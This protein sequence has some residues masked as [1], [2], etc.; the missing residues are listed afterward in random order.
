MRRHGCA[1]E[2]KKGGDD[3][4]GKRMFGAG[5]HSGRWKKG[6]DGKEGAE[7]RGDVRAR[8]CLWSALNPRIDGGVAEGRW[9]RAALRRHPGC[10]TVQGVTAMWR[11]FDGGHHG[12]GTTARRGSVAEVSLARGRIR[13]TRGGSV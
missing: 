6:A 9:G 3:K 8:R 13:C 2:E 11:D 7:G 12:E 5:R 4:E 10:V 1:G